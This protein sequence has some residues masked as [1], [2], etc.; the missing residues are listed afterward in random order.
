MHTTSVAFRVVTGRKFY[1]LSMNVCFLKVACITLAKIYTEPIR[2]RQRRL[3][4]HLL[5]YETL[6]FHIYGQYGW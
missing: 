4:W 6:A 1:I 3:V 5:F 2:I